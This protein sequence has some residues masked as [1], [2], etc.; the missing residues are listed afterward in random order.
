MR[1]LN[2]V[3]LIGNLTRDPELRTTP[4]GQTVAS[5]AIACNRSWNDQQGVKQDA[6]EYVNIVAWGKL[7]EIVGQIYK[8][9]RRTYI[10]G[11][12][13]TSSWDDKDTGAKRYKT[14][15][16]ANDLILLDRPPGA[17]R[18]E[19][20]TSQN[21]AQPAKEPVSVTESGKSQSP[22]SAVKD[23]EIN[24]DDIPF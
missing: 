9:G 2:K 17:G 11:R 19:E 16:V 8:K 15:V 5:F 7:A 1:D 23:D 10:E 21:Q 24:I 12:M 4:N 3:M 20:G 6:V 22:V 14:E 18:E 13:Q